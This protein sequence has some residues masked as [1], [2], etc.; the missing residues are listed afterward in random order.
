MK[1]QFWLENNPKST[2]RTLTNHN[3]S[4]VLFFWW[5]GGLIWFNK[6][7]LDLYYLRVDFMHFSFFVLYISYMILIAKDDL[8][9]RLS[10]RE[11]SDWLDTITFGLTLSYS[12]KSFDRP[13]CFS[14]FPSVYVCPVLIINSFIVHCSSFVVQLYLS[15]LVLM[16]LN[17]WLGIIYTLL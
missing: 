3:W 6:M 9:V 7:R 8:L 11:F 13:C 1:H 16:F 12:E 17:F 15:V 14:A 5:K 2:W 10:G 4:F